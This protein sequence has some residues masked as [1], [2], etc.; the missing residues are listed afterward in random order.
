[1][2]DRVII[3]GTRR[4]GEK[5][6]VS[7]LTQ[8]KGRAG[9]VPGSTGYVDIIVAESD[10]DDLVEELQDIEN[11]RVNSVMNEDDDTVGFHLIAEICN[12][13]IE[14]VQ[15]AKE[16]MSRSFAV[17]TGED[18]PVDLAI[19]NLCML[20]MI[21][22]RGDFL[23][24]LDMGRIAA[25]LYFAPKDIYTWKENF[26]EIFER[27]LED[28]EFAV[29]WALSNVPRERRRRDVAGYWNY[30]DEYKDQVRSNGLECEGTAMAGLIWWSI[31]G[32]PS[33]GKLSSEI[34]SVKDD[35]GRIFSALKKLNQLSD[36][37][38]AEFF[39]R[40]STQ[41]QY[42]VTDELAKLCSAEGIGKG[43]AQELYSIGVESPQEINERW[44]SIETECGPTL[45][46][47]LRMAGYGD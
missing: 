1:M 44:S 4:A 27:G 13:S 25:S 39:E 22:R 18:V 7:E 32:G 15:N 19:E 34:R 8:M 5:V 26:S 33:L 10:A 45:I 21:F 14:S 3:V 2:A 43:M 31:M 30:L 38:M 17:F 11:L 6:P 16:W 37:G 20:K 36:W 29:I 24:P 41:V 47:K 23:I 9:R 35:F 46:D 12:G 28:E 40:I 42:R